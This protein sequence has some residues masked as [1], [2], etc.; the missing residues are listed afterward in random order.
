MQFSS[1]KGSTE[2]PDEYQKPAQSVDSGPESQGSLSNQSNQ[3]INDIMKEE[4]EHFAYDDLDRGSNKSFSSGGNNT[5][6]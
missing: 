6:K 4:Q 5:A 2:H 3:R 1:P